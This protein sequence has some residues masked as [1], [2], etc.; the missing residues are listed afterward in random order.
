MNVVDLIS[1]LEQR[2]DIDTLFDQGSFTVK[3]DKQLGYRLKR[4]VNELDVTVIPSFVV[5][6]MVQYKRLIC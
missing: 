3:G 2:L 6:M 1:L 4:V 5:N